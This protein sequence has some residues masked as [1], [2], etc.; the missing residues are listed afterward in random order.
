MAR[1]R[2]PTTRAARPIPPVRAGQDVSGRAPKPIPPGRVGQGTPVRAPKPI[3]P[4][5]AGQNVSGRAARPTPA[6]KAAFLGQA[7]R[8]ARQN[9]AASRA[10][11][12][13]RTVAPKPTQTA[14]AGMPAVRRKRG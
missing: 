6:A 12:P 13:P 1:A 2:K 3:P 7:T 10:A 14:R 9:L 5:R 8:R 4:V 11:A